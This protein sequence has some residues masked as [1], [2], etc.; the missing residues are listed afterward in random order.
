MPNRRTEL[1]RLK[2]TDIN[3]D[4]ATLT[5]KQNQSRRAHVVP[6]SPVA[7]EILSSIRQTGPWVFSTT[8]AAPIQGFSWAKSML[9]ACLVGRV[10]HIDP[11]HIHDLRRTSNSGMARLTI[12]PHVLS[13][14]LHH[15]PT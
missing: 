14:D 7:L 11:W 13:A 12:P 15:A 9:N 1:E 8:Q 6:L 4:D 5:M 2:R 10:E 3:S